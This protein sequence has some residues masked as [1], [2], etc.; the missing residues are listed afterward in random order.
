MKRKTLPALLALL[1]AALYSVNIPLSKLLLGKVDSVMMAGLLYL[2]A[3]LGLLIYSLISKAV[4][5]NVISEPLTKKELPYTV[6]MVILDIAAPILLMIGITKCSSANVSL[7]NNLEIVATTLV[8][9][10]IFKE[11]VSKKLA[12]AIALVVISGVI[13]TFEG[14]SAFDFSAGSLYVVGACACWGME[15]N[16]TR[17]LSH[18]SSVEITTIKGIFSGLGSILVGFL[19]GSLLPQWIYIS[20]VMALG[21]VSYGLS[22][23]FYIMAQKELGA[24]KTS[25][26]YAVAPFL[27]VLF[28]MLLLGEQPKLNFYI[29]LVIMIAATLLIVKD[30]FESEKLS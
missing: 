8:A 13:L 11:T 4:G 22:I 19:T 5:K 18:K 6:A 16:C 20:A 3:G 21:F 15:N 23:N 7:L 9:M 27:G 26:Y 30:T 28:S 2:G 10:V 12:V 29:A 14:I 1:A 17:N 25:A 24:A